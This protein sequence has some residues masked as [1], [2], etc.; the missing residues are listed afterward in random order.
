MS[1]KTLGILFAILFG[2]FGVLGYFSCKT[3]EE[4]KDFI[5]GWGKTFLIMIIIALFIGLINL[6]IYLC[7]SQ[8]YIYY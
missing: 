7:V 8:N 2:I 4:E 5:S 6:G 3:E 1:K